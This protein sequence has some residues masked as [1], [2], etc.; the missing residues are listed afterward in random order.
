MP[1]KMNVKKEA[2][3]HEDLRGFDIK[4]D[5]FGKMESSFSIDK[6]NE[7]LNEKVSDKRLT[8]STEEE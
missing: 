3:S 8:H 5:P 4:V 1:K 2:E 7:F 6:L